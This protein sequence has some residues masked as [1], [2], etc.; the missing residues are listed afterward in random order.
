MKTG[1]LKTGLMKYLLLVLPINKE[2]YH[3]LG[4]L[5]VIFGLNSVFTVKKKEVEYL[6]RILWNIFTN[7]KVC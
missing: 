6:K 7:K 5:K 1:N 4:I 3:Y 2:R